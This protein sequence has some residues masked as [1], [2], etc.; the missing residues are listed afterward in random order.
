MNLRL[1][2]ISHAPTAAMRAGRFP[3][4]D[5]LD[6]RGLGQRP[7]RA[8]LNLSLKFADDAAAFVS[9]ALCA[10]DTSSALGLIGQTDAAL[11][12]IDY[13]NWRG[14]RLN[15]LAAHTPE[16]LAAWTR[17]PD[18]APHGGESFSQV[19]TRIGGWLDALAATPDNASADERHVVALTHAPVIRAA[20][21]HVLGASPAI[22]SRME[23]APL[24]VVELRHSRQRGWSWLP[25]AS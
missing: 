4:D 22:F 10:R 20:I 2:L 7:P 1:L 3:A 23:I 25:A 5:P 17:D 24:S 12:D 16:A 18:A 21:V 15:E 19:V 6:A 8:R 9:P 14:Q 13:G 11:A